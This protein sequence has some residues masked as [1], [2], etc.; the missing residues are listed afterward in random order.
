MIKLFL[1]IL[2]V[3]AST[4]V[5]KNVRASVLPQNRYFNLSTSTNT[6]PYKKVITAYLSYSLVGYEGAD[7]I[8]RPVLSRGI[9]QIFNQ[10]KNQWIG[11]ADLW[12]NMPK[13]EKEVKLKIDVSGSSDLWF[14]IQNVT[15]AQ[16][17]ETPKTTIWG[18]NIFT[19]YID[20]LNKNAKMYVL[21]QAMSQNSL[22]EM[23]E[24]NLNRQKE[25]QKQKPAHLLA[26]VIKY[27]GEII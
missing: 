10:E 27:I 20:K 18:Q 5:G 17:Y 24:T 26:K 22:K 12:S 14:Q 15:N 2:Y 3:F 16:I 21:E 19:D 13:L 23:D 9:V 6:V 7:F 11:Q 1:I 4:F 25:G 8:I